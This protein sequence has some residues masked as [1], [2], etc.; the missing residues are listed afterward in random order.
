MLL[1]IR[2]ALWGL[3]LMLGPWGIFVAGIVD[4]AGVPLPCAVDALLVTY[5][6]KTPG[7]AWLYVAL[8]VVGSMIGC[9]VLYLIGYAGGELLLERRM[10][11][12]KFQKIS[13]DFDRN[14]FLTIAVPALL[15]PPFPFKAFVLAAGAF[16]IRWTHFLLAVLAGRVV[17][18]TLLAVLTITIGPEVLV[19]FGGLIRQHPAAAVAVLAALVALGFL[20]HRLRQNSAKANRASSVALDSAEQSRAD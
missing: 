12:E 18:Y 7:Q 1:K 14:A 10:S 11:P 13:R 2:K 16:E 6:F 17:R 3:M 20:V 15:P 8:A 5:V 4:S 19:L 9:L